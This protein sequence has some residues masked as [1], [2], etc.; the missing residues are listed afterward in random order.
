[1]ERKKDDEMLGR[2][3]SNVA[4][5]LRGPLANIHA[6]ARRMAPAER[7]AEDPRLDQAAAI[8]SQSYYRLLR[9]VGNLTTAAELFGDE[10]LYLRDEDLA[11]LCREVCSGA[12]H[13]AEQQGQEVRFSSG[14]TS[15]I[16]ACN[17]PAMERLLLN[18][19]SNAMKFA[20][21]GP[22]VVELRRLEELGQVEICVTDNGCGISQELLP[23]IFD[24]YLHV[25]RMDPAPY[26]LGLGLPICHRIAMAH[27]G[28]IFI[29][30]T[31]GSGTQVTVRIPDRQSPT[32]QVNTPR[33]DYAGGFNH[34]MLE[35]SDALGSR[36]FLQEKGEAEG[37]G[38]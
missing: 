23:T 8:F 24:R 29:A 7:R 6:A 11:A 10:P 3:L 35:L 32:V 2:L 9:V 5:Q 38:R 18:L 22:I 15:C 37:G 25:E 28:E 20:P 13:L 16:V 14:E 12:A 1:M 21:G 19:L 34:T 30:S 4:S 36:V 27:E 17:R 31:L 26:G 33:F